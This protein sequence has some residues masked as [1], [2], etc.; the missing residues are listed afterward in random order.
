MGVNFFIYIL[1]AFAFSN[2]P[3][4]SVGNSS[5]ATP[6]QNALE[7][8]AKAK[9]ESGSQVSPADPENFVRRV[10]EPFRYDGNTE[11]DP[12]VQPISINPLQPGPYFGPFLEL[13][14]IKLDSVKLKGVFLDPT[15]P[16]ALIQVK[17][18]SAEKTF[19]LQKGDYIG[20]NFGYVAAIREG[21]VI[22]VQTLDQG[23]KKYSTTRTIS[24][25][26]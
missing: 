17:I 15:R 8:Q 4:V 23:N 11:R 16:I 22:V 7:S 21:E 9:E 20:E 18:G 1:M 19:R 10:T 5:P 26:K 13:Q 12:F 24:R 6:G 2:E 3:Q 14:E 25:E